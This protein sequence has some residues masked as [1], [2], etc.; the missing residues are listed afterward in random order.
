MYD[1]YYESIQKDGKQF[2]RVCK[3]VDVYENRGKRIEF[4][5]DDDYVIAVFRYKG[6]LYCL[7]NICPHRHQDQIHNGIIKDGAVTCP[8]HGWTYNLH[9]GSNVIQRQGIKSLKSFDIFEEKG[10]VYIE[11]P[12]IDIPKWRRE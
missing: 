2:F 1:D 3:S 6:D 11:K 8:L 10:Y 12:E 4:P 9:D 7:W 5:G